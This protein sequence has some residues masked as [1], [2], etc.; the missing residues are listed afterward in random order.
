MERRDELHGLEELAGIDG[1]R[2]HGW[3]KIPE[4]GFFHISFGCF[5]QTA[6]N[7]EVVLFMYLSYWI[8]QQNLH[9]QNSAFICLR[10][11]Q[12]MRKMRAPL[13]KQFILR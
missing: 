5:V 8:F 4:R 3:K 9:A 11:I 1:K 12:E 10:P 6:E 2:E 13:G 7:R